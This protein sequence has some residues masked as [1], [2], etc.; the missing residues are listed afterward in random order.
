MT[1]YGAMQQRILLVEDESI[2]RANIADLLKANGYDVAEARDGAQAVELLTE[3]S[4]DLIITDL[5]M[6]QMNGFK[7]IARVRSFDRALP[8]ILITAFLSTQSGE[9]ILG[10]SAEFIGKPIDPGVLLT[11]VNRLVS[12]GD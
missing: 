3:R 1:P 7:L 2:T 8:V 5:V 10:G 9:A 11:A 6:P 12:R 4:F